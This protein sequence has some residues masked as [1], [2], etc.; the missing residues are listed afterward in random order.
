MFLMEGGS[1]LG[2]PLGIFFFLHIH[3][4]YFLGD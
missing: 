2:L 3:D 1:S 4:F